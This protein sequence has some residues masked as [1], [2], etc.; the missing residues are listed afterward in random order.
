MSIQLPEAGAASKALCLKS[1]E[2]WMQEAAAAGVNLTNFDPL[3]PLEQRLAWAVSVG[4][5]IG[6]ILSRYSTVVQHS[7]ESQVQ[8]NICFAARNKIYVPP[9]F[10]CVDEAQSGKRANRDGIERIKLILK[11]RLATI[12]IVFKM[13]RLLR[14]GYKSFGFVNEQVVEEGLRAISVSQGI[15]TDDQKSWKSLMYLHGMMDELLLDTIADHV[16][17]GLANLFSEGYVIGALTVGYEGEDIEGAP[18][19]NRGLPRRRPK[20]NERVRKL[21]QQHYEWIRDGMSIREGLKRWIAANGPYDPRSTTK[22]MTYSAY[23]RMLSNHRYRGVW[24]FGRKRNSWSSKRGYN[25]QVEQ[26]ESEVTIFMCEELRIVS[27]KLFFEVQEVLAKKKK[28]PRGPRPDKPKRLWDLVTDCFFC[29]ACSHD[30][31]LVRMYQGGK[32]NEGMFCKSGVLCKAPSSIRR[33]DAV[34]AVC[35]ALQDHIRND[36]ELLTRIGSLAIQVDEGPDED[37]EERKRSLQRQERELTNR[38]QFL[39]RLGGKE[40]GDNDPEIESEYCTVR[41][42]RA[43]VQEHLRQLDSDASKFTKVT[44]D[45]ANAILSDFTTLL[46]NGA[47]GELDQESVHQ[48]ATVFRLLVGGRVMAHI[49]PR[50]ARKQTN[51]RGVFRIHLIRAFAKSSNTEHLFEDECSDEVSVWLRKPP[52]SDLLAPHVHDLIDNQG[53]S[54]RAAA[55]VLCEEGHKV[56]SGVVYNIYYRYYEMIGEPVPDRPYN[57]GIPR[58]EK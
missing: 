38:M 8:E 44:L 9:E 16:R 23:R 13:S 3:A 22:R 33:E 4:L 26:P 55:K 27:D 41:T 56:N 25:L 47:A 31:E 17:A 21:I 6:A 40:D 51:V 35:N 49:E 52:R 10:I 50:P 32:N 43:T 2:W 42:N 20:V 53:M 29:A 58:K 1:I 7:T 48:A 28:G 14:S 37:F 24:A 34:R 15:D 36:D 12:L 19:T 57:N 30:G 5:D 18:L 39:L 45:S 46:E 11:Q 54:F